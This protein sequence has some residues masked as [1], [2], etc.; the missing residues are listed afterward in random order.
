VHNPVAHG[1]SSDTDGVIRG[2]KAGRIS[3][4]AFCPGNFARFPGVENDKRLKVIQG[5]N[6]LI[7]GVLESH[8][9]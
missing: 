4:G 7:Y 2:N 9:F 8:S 5:Y 1:C 3:V 6:A